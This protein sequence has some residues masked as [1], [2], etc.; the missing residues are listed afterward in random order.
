M[1][2]PYRSSS[3]IVDNPN[4]YEGQWVALIPNNKTPI[5][6]GENFLEVVEE[7]KKIHN[8][9]NIIMHKILCSGIIYAL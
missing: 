1:K 3:D 8:I 9:E 6:H 5:A 7:A 2:I 4:K